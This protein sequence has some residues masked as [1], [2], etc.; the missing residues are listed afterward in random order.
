ME[1][2]S[3]LIHNVHH[4]FEGFLKK[5]KQE[6]SELNLKVAK[7][8][9]IAHRCLDGIEESRG[10]NEKMGTIMTCMLEFNSIAQ[11]LQF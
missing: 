8:Q 6:H 2:V 9:E 10:S 11:A 3:Q 4:D 5:H 7:M 1:E